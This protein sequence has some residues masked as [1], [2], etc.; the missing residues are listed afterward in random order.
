MIKEI[1]D[2]ETILSLK[3]SLDKFL[4]NDDCKKI[5][6]D[7]CIHDRLCSNIYRLNT[8]LRARYLRGVEENLNK[9]DD[10]FFKFELDMLGL[11][12]LSAILSAV[13]FKQEKVFE[14][15]GDGA[16]RLMRELYKQTHKEK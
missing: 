7:T 2:K 10:V 12:Q 4:D 16:D 3:N 8:T 1:E 5:D 9:E 14:E 15:F 13:A 6:C 11:F